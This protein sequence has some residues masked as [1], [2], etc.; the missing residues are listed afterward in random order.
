[1]AFHND[2]FDDDQQRKRPLTVEFCK[3]RVKALLQT[4]VSS[5]IHCVCELN[6]AETAQNVTSNGANA[7]DCKHRRKCLKP[8]EAFSHDWRKYPDL[9]ECFH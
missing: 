5:A 4:N 9:L 3:S 2:Q 8:D 7:A 1:L 6:L